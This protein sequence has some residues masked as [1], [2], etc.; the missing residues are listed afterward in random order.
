MAQPEPEMQ[1]VADSWGAEEAYAEPVQA[2]PVE[3][4][5]DDWANAYQQPADAAPAQAQAGADVPIPRMQSGG[6][7]Q[8]DKKQEQAM[9]NVALLPGETITNIWEADGV[10]LEAIP[11]AKLAAMI[12]RF[13]LMITGGY[14]RVYL[15]LTNQRLIVVQATRDSCGLGS[16]RVADTLAASAIHTVG[17][18]KQSWLFCCHSRLVRLHSKKTPL[19]LIMRRFKD[20]D[21]RSFM[22]QMAVHM[23]EHC[24]D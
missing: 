11:G 14:I 5:A 19:T 21:A 20:E 13:I 15:V 18:G 9:A 12:Q 22:N 4:P 17:I 6:A 23:M 7:V 10:I 24:T 16:A 2:R 3:A 1:P 8:L